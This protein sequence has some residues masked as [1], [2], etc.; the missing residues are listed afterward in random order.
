MKLTK[1]LAAFNLIWIIALTSGYSQ[2]PEEKLSLNEGTIENQFNY[3]IKKSNTYEDYKMVRSWWLYRLKTHVTDSMKT[4]RQKLTAA[5]ESISEKEKEI[6]VLQTNLQATN[7]K[8]STAIKEKNSLVFFGITMNKTAYNTIVWGIIAGL[9]VFLGLFII[10][11]KR[12]NAVTIQ[13][14]RSLNELKTE[15]E[16]YRKRA[17]EREQKTVRRLYDEILK[18]K[19]KVTKV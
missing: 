3:V 2:K 11:F 10:L 13:T 16:D 5:R 19:S 8:L 6:N 18:Y 14:K 1:L 4:E 15:Y 12:S 17:L 7:D 9:A